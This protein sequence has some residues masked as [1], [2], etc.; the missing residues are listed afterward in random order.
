MKIS[1]AIEKIKAYHKGTINGQPID[2]AKTRDK[3]LWGNP[4][5]ELTGV[6]VTCYASVEVVK[7]ALRLGANLI[8]PHEALFW[9][10]GDHTDWLAD[11]ETFKD[12]SAL[13]D[14]GGIVVWRD[15][16]YI[17]SGIPLEDGTWTDGIFYGLMKE[18]GWDAYLIDDVSC[19]LKFSIPRTT[20][21]EL[22][23]D[24]M[25]KF[26]LRGMKVIGDPASPSEKVWVCGHIDGR[27]DN[28]ILKIT[29]EEGIDTLI[30]LECTD[31]TVAEYVRDSTM[32]GHPKT[33]LAMGHFNTEEPGMKYMAS[34]LP[35]VLGGEVPVT[36]V[37]CTDMYHF[38]HK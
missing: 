5:Q 22:G 27:Q 14:Q 24:L 25:E 12:K 18:L 20:A 31:Y 29:E 9:N 7:E 3:I 38:L 35:A 28:Q 10:H 19:P 16:D 26:D 36:F 37:P 15:H 34:W 11:N 23:R 32:L 2:P 17:H 8:V 4:D 1:E 13:L 6:V 33:I 21:G 30:T